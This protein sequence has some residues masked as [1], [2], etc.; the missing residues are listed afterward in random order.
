M[1]SYQEILQAVQNHTLSV[2]EATEALRQADVEDLGFANLDHQRLTRKG[3]TEVVYCEGKTAEQSATILA[4]LAARNGG[5]VL[6]TRADW[7]VQELLQGSVPDA[8]YDAVSRTITI[9]RGEQKAIGHVAIVAAGTSDLPVAEEA[10]VTAAT[11][12]NHVDRI[13][14]VGVA[15]LHRLLRQVE[16]LRRAR[17]IIAVAGMEGALVS[18]LTGLVDRPVIGVPTSVGYGAQLQGMTPLFSMLTSCV[19]GL[20]VVNIDNGFGAGYMASLINQM[21]GIEACESPS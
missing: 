14:D 18:V 3:F 15:G 12:G 6:G 2:E 21:G 10:A 20:A 4:H 8:Q 13:Y 19:P 9:R 16:R 1:P 7:A 11:M 17:V 5:N